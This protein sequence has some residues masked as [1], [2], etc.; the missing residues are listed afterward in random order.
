MSPKFWGSEPGWRAM[1]F[2]GLPQNFGP[3]LNQIMWLRYSGE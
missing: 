3:S 1:N 2:Q